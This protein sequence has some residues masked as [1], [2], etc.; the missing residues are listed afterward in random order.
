[1]CFVKNFQR[2]FLVS[3]LLS[4][5]PEEVDVWKFLVATLNGHVTES[6]EVTIPCSHQWRNPFEIKFAPMPIKFGIDEL[7]A[8]VSNKNRT[9]I[10]FS[11]D[12]WKSL[13]P[14]NK[15]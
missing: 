11:V 13:Y 6:A 5:N 10:R 9:P 4:K 15:G 8:G 3:K 2:I 12:F 7:E 1:M 14:L